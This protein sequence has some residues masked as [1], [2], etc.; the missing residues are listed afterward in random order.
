ME[1]DHI[2]DVLATEGFTVL[3]EHEPH[4]VFVFTVEGRFVLANPTMRKLLGSE[5]L[6]LDGVRFG[7]RLAERDRDRALVEFAGAARG[8][9][10]TVDADVVRDDGSRVPGRFTLV[11]LRHAGD[12][13]AVIGYASDLHE[14]E[15]AVAQLAAQAALLDNARDAI[16][17][18]ELDST[19]RYWNRSAARIYG[20]TSAEVVGRRARDLLYDDAAQYEHA[21]AMTLEH[22]HWAGELH[23][24]AKDGSALIVDSSWT[25][26]RRDD[27]TPESVFTV[28]ADITRRKQREQLELRTAPHGESRNAGKR[29]RPRPQ[30]RAD[31]D[32]D[33]RP[34]AAV[35]RG[36]PEQKDI[37]ASTELAVKRGADMIRQVLSFATGASGRHDPIDLR[38]LLAEL[39]VVCSD[40][41][42]ADIRVTFDIPPDLW[43]TS[44]RL[45]PAAP[46]A[47]QPGQQCA[48]RPVRPGAGSA[49][50]SHND[51][52]ARHLHLGQPSRGA[53]QLRRHR[54]GG[55]RY[56]DRPGD[57]RQDLRTVLHH[58]GDRLRHRSGAV[59]LDRDRARARRLHAGIQRSGNGVAVPHPPSRCT[60][61]R[62]PVAAIA[63]DEPRTSFRWARAS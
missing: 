25:L 44:G 24:V 42:P 27:G 7:D 38:T 5:P 18:R 20:W 47:A 46:G 37:L 35:D 9:I 48:R 28:S 1:I 52:L 56:G 13:V 61:A 58:Q 55:R 51:V 60:A 57:P 63:P 39:E 30:Q 21:I 49:V 3:F 54:G 53:G 16:I 4:G 45:D 59:D 43:G 15:E 14:L 26:T 23:Q 50:R 19:V 6:A 12:V 29:D 10:R 8:E 2:R 17:V 31:A 22:G 32:P 36:G 62:R 40:S 34:T 41:L 11:P 33:G